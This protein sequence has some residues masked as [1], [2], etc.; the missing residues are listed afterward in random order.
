MTT[1]LGG[2]PRGVDSRD[3]RGVGVGYNRQGWET[4]GGEEHHRAV[5][6]REQ[7]TDG[8]DLIA[9]DQEGETGRGQYW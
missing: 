4:H 3:T 6:R 9:R 7:K 5:N 2:V 8:R 1:E